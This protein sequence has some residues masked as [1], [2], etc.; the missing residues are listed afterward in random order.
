[1]GFI[2]HAIIGVAL[3]EAVKYLI[4][5]DRLEQQVEFGTDP[6]SS[7]TGRGSDEDD[8]WKNSL[9]DDTLRAPD[10]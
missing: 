5:Q 3:Y 1:M 9:A 10:S 7:F 4:R 8:P 2:K 6:E